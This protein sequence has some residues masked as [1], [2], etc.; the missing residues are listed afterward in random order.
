M[1]SYIDGVALPLYTIMNVRLFAEIVVIVHGLLSSDDYLPWW[2]LFRVCPYKYVVLCFAFSFGLGQGHSPDA[3]Q[4]H[5]GAP[6]QDVLTWD[7]YSISV[8]IELSYSCSC[9]ADSNHFRCH[10]LA[11][12]LNVLEEPRSGADALVL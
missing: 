12:G 4:L 8:R 9:R 2:L 6:L 3:R 5:Q 1:A 7:R 10:R 11:P